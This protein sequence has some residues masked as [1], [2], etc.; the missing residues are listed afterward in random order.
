MKQKNTKKEQQKK[1]RE[2]LIILNKIVCV[3]IAPS[4]I[5]G[6]GVFALRNLNKDEK[7]NLDA[8][9]HAF[10]LPY[11]MFQHLKP[12][13]KEILLGHWPQI[14]NGSHFLYPVTKMT[15]FLNHSNTPNYD[16]KEDKVLTDIQKGEEVTE[17]Y[18]KILNFEKIFPWITS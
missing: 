3:R 1:L 9:P 17:D 6:V 7:L 12:E 4:S 5:H 8:I 2:A 16:A 18:R 10:D 15:A 11:K 14:I 13:I